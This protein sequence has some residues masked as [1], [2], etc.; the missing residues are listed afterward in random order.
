MG[1]NSEKRRVAVVLSGGVAKG[2]YEVGVL[3]AL[4]AKGI[5]PDIYC[6][7]SVGA[8]NAAMLV[9]GMPLCQVEQVWRG[10]RR[11]DVF[12]VRLDPRQLL[13]IDPRV[14]LGLAWHLAESSVSLGAD[15]VKNRGAWWR[16]F[17][18][19]DYLSDI[20]PLR[21]LI[22]TKV[23]LAGLQSNRT[24]KALYI[25]LTRLNPTGDD[26]LEV[27]SNQAGKLG[28]YALKGPLTHEHILAACAVPL[29][30]P[31]IEIDGRAYCDGGV[32]MNTP[33]GLAVDAGADDIYVVDLTAIP[34][35]YSDATLPLAYQTLSAAFG[36][37]LRRDLAVAHDRNGEVLAAFGEDRLVKRGR[38][39]GRT[40][41]VLEVKRKAYRNGALEEMTRAYRYVRLYVITPLSDLGGLEGFLDFD[42]DIAKEW[43]RQGEEEA[44]WILAHYRERALESKSG[45]SM[46]VVDH[47]DELVDPT[48][49]TWKHLSDHCNEGVG[50]LS[51]LGSHGALMARCHA[52]HGPLSE[53]QRLYEAIRTG[54]ALSRPLESFHA[55]MEAFAERV[56]PR[57]R[58]VPHDRGGKALGLARAVVRHFHEDLFILSGLPKPDPRRATLFYL[59]LDQLSQERFGRPFREL[60]ADTQ[61]FLLS[62]LENR[63]RQ[64][65]DS[66][67]SDTDIL[68]LL[69]LEQVL[70]V[71]LAYYANYPEI[72][73][74]QADGAPIYSDQQNL[75]SNPNKPGTG[76]AWD[77]IAYPGPVQKQREDLLWQAY[78]KEDKS[79][80]KE[81]VRL[82]RK[83]QLP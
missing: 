35:P 58:S 64:M 26:A 83:G 22:A 61:D 40:E 37:S 52:G 57:D 32:V 20:A 9:S 45:A 72:V 59:E 23:K 30:L 53:L 4:H 7:T 27:W 75:I 67:S 5:E 19:A 41:H 15:T 47:T 71:K 73:E 68:A 44:T 78:V 36:A 11:D 63:A 12:R 81:L 10:L 54:I 24:S 14:P 13:T 43:I 77:Y 65:I 79:A 31:P 18:L 21:G 17:N 56:V 25:T 51:V 69:F 60:E 66:P 29:V 16:A 50:T 8:F 74:R 38:A 34:N 33:V 6:G 42:P 82:D 39:G 48:A 49:F 1:S 70:L 28:R 46:L 80:L 55:T 62:H 76:T 2:A 3:N